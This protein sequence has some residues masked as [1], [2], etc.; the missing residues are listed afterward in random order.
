MPAETVLAAA[1]LSP[2]AGDIGAN[3][4]LHLAYAQRAA[5]EGARLL[6]FPELSLTGY[7]LDRAAELAMDVGDPRLGPLA[8]LAAARSL[9]LVAG[10]PVRDATGALRLAALV[11]DGRAGEGQPR[12]ALYAKQRLGAFTPEV[13]PSG[14]IPPPEG[15]VFAPGSADVDVRCGAL[16]AGLAIC[17]DV[18]DPAHAARAAAR[19]A[20]AYLVSAFVVTA[21]CAAEH[22]RLA[23]RART[24]Q[25]AVL[26]ANYTG[27]S[28]GL[29]AAG[30]SALWTPSGDRVACLAAGDKGLVIGRRGPRG[31]LGETVR[32]ETV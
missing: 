30:G 8:E 4:A 25:M 13:N 29:P 1:Q 23:E 27:T 2:V 26:L 7:E 5:R 11:F 14:P 18:G 12:L 17:A 32:V 24:H 9:I 28:G 20:G 16:S 10:A 21:E 22:Q 31:W 3:V 19:D 15:T 6:L